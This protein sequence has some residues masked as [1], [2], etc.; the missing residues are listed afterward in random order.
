MQNIKKKIKFIGLNKPQEQYT[1][2]PSLFDNQESNFFSQGNYNE[3]ERYNDTN[4]DNSTESFKQSFVQENNQTKNS[5]GFFHFGK[6]NK[7]SKNTQAN[8]HSQT[9]NQSQESQAPKNSNQN[10][11]NNFGNNH[12]NN[13]KNSGVNAN[14]PYQVAAGYKSQNKQQT[15]QSYS[16]ATDTLNLPKFLAKNQFKNQPVQNNEF[17]QFG[18]KRIDPDTKAQ[19]AKALTYIPPQYDQDPNSFTSNFSKDNQKVENNFRVFQKTL[20][21]MA[22]QLISYFCLI[23]AFLTGNVN[24]FFALPFNAYNA[25]GGNASA[26]SI[27]GSLSGVVII[28]TLT[29]I[30]AVVSSIFAV[31]VADRIYVWVALL[32]QLVSL[33]FCFSF[34]GL[35]FTLPTVLVS[36]LCAMIFYFG[37][38]EIEKIQVSSRLF[39]IQYITNE[40]VKLFTQ[41]AILTATLVIFNT[42]IFESPKNFLVNRVLTNEYAS[43]F[44]FEKKPLLKGD[45]LVENNTVINK[46]DKQP[47]TIVDFIALNYDLGLAPKCITTD[48][49]PKCDPALEKLTRATAF[50]ETKFNDNSVENSIFKTKKID[51]KLTPDEFKK[52]LKEFYVQK[53]SSDLTKGFDRPELAFVGKV[54][55]VEGG[56]WFIPAISALFFYIVMTII[57]PILHIFANILIWILWKFLLLTGFSKVNV[58]L[59]ES[60][61]ISI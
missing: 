47:L 21:F 46:T 31:I 13:S 38:L 2:K 8:E 4:S 43:N 12:I 37:Y 42:I 19:K 45:Y 61:I 32:V 25:L 15:E 39:N 57:K 10:S 58:E 54:L 16:T 34:L 18:R 44:L 17:A 55:G 11:K 56:S 48:A 20:I 49:Q 22:L 30:Y 40:S 41:I 50:V 24:N 29:I 36:V 53:F 33:I 60:E 14:S 7:E 6:K 5:G 59:V 27:L 26:S 51:E 28:S 52:V 23:F 3:S 9:S 35:G 1:P